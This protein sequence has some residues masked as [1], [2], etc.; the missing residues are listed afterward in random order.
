MFH[1]IFV[2]AAEFDLLPGR[3]KVYVFKNLLLKNH[4]ENEAD[5]LHTC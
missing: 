1:M 2:Q 5:I 3:H 4:K